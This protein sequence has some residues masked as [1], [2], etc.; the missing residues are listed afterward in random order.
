M[1]FK[2][3]EK[4]FR[5]NESHTYYEETEDWMAVGYYEDT[6]TFFIAF[7]HPGYYD[8]GTCWFNRVFF[9]EVS[10][11]FFIDG[12]QIGTSD[13]VLEYS[14]DAD[15]IVPFAGTNIKGWEDFHVLISKM[16]DEVEIKES[17]FKLTLKR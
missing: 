6:E 10:N 17:E 9:D 13:G 14:Y 12:I 8:E 16:L 2:E 5:F 4:L 7:H 1:T 11:K 15:D 3:L